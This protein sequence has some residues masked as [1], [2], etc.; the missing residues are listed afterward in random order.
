MHGRAGQCPQLHAKHL[1]PRQREAD[2]AQAKKWIALA[3]DGQTCDRLVAA[4]IEGADR[5]RPSL[6]PVE[7]PPVDRILGVLVRQA[8]GRLEQK[9]RAHEADAVADGGIEAREIFRRGDVEKDG[10]SPAVCRAGG[11]SAA[12]VGDS[13]RGVRSR[14]AVLEQAARFRLGVEDHGAGIAIDERQ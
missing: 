8:A 2:A 1:R 12:G 10:D 9:F 5:H 7:N 11:F 4:G 6:G 14:H 3:V 13:P